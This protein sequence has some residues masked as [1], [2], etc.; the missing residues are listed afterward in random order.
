[1]MAFAMGSL[2][3]SLC[4]SHKPLYLGLCYSPL[5]K[6]PTFHGYVGAAPLCPAVQCTAHEESDTL[7]QEEKHHKEVERSPSW[8]DH[9]TP[10]TPAPVAQP[11][12]LPDRYAGWPPFDSD[13]K[14]SW[15]AGLL[16]VGAGFMLAIGFSFAAY[17]AY[18]RFGGKRQIGVA[19]L[20]MQQQQASIA[21]E[22]ESLDAS[23]NKDIIAESVEEPKYDL[24]K[25][26]ENPIK[27]YPSI[28]NANIKVD[29]RDA[30]KEAQNAASEPTVES[31]EKTDLPSQSAVSSPSF[32]T[33][34]VS[35]VHTPASTQ[36][37][38]IQE[39]HSISIQ[40]TDF[41]KGSDIS[42]SIV[43]AINP[44]AG[45]KEQ[46]PLEEVNLVEGPVT[47][48]Q[49]HQALDEPAISSRSAVN[50]Q[51][52]PNKEAKTGVDSPA[53][54]SNDTKGNSIKVDQTF[55]GADLLRSS[56]VYIPAPLS[57]AAA[58]KSSPGK[59]VI[60]AVVDQMQQHALEAL[61]ALKVM[62]P[63]VVAGDI[64]TRRE[65]A[66][67][68]IAS[69]GRLARST[70]HKVFPAMYIENVTQ[71][72]F[73]DLSAEDPDF[74]F[75]QGLA[76]AGLISSNLSKTGVVEKGMQSG[77][78][79]E[80][81]R[82][83]SRQDLVTWKVALDRHQL[84]TIDKEALQK[85]SGFVDV[86]QI[87]EDA[88]PALMADL[89][90]AKPSI[91]ASAFGF[92]R[93]FQPEKPTTKGQAAIAL[94]SGDAADNVAEELARLE[95]EA[96]A[97][98]AVAADIAMELHA[99]SDI[100]DDF[101]KQLQ[102]EKEK[103]E[104]AEK[105]IEEVR[106]EL[107]KAK[108]ERDEERYSVLKDRATLDSEKELLNVLRQQVD[109]QL[110]AFS[111]LRVEV[112]AEKERLE[113]L[114]VEREEQLKAIS[115]YKLELEVERRALTLVRSWAED[116]AK[117]AQAQGQILEEARKRW[118]NQGFEDVVGEDL[119][120]QVNDAI[121]KSWQATTSVFYS[122]LH[123]VSSFLQ[124]FGK[125]VNLLQN[126]VM[127]SA[128]ERVQ[129]VQEAVGKSTQDVQAAVG[130]RVQ[131][132]QAAVGS[133]AQNLQAT[134]ATMSTNFAVR[135]KKFADNCKGEAEKLAQRFKHE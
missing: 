84:S 41:K 117:Q 90:V 87:Q 4:L 23:S 89:T 35:R 29:T 76:E 46:G 119:K 133:K 34:A 50:L 80:P 7:V 114:R 100:S 79:F 9:D 25:E 21:E 121:I 40:L 85:E 61:Q 15:E 60:P 53:D 83:L 134:V 48:G 27:G 58:A 30:E 43:K 106:S 102:A 68:L 12:P 67:W 105:L 94:A 70:A 86:D 5:L 59:V 2:P 13:P 120:S 69:S 74:P 124:E 66:R 108:A 98:K 92:T 125:K 16:K 64:C 72:A 24:Q 47:K 38:E 3:T 129:H 71:H 99:R 107:Q 73:D 31:A 130:E 122:L 126:N 111:G 17:S 6:G 39:G 63:D 32:E 110:Q 135:S 62:D 42:S 22:S 116:E 20:M 37:D 91:I 18:S 81:D 127:S 36:Q 97:E 101:N 131:G 88:W 75:I 26:R 14:G 132:V 44:Q 95:A 93:R 33:A 49:W 65:Y 128:G 10:T 51:L 118:E 113:K 103:R 123:R 109:E 115:N 8:S 82:P 55:R 78:F 28:T 77:V 56:S 45:V 19:P 112:A 11:P 52:A 104:Q 1:M 96:M 57:A 54:E